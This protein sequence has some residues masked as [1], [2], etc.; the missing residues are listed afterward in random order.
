MQIVPS[1]Y[2]VCAIPR[3]AAFDYMRHEQERL[4]SNWFAYMRNKQ[5][6]QT[7]TKT[8]GD[9]AS[10]CNRNSVFEDSGGMIFRKL[11]I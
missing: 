6:W 9:H 7:I 4:L 10:Q 2:T 8:D 1:Q 11:E 5:T 3:L